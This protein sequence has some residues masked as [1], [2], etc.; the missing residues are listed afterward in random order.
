MSTLAIDSTV[1]AALIGA[2]ALVVGKLIAMVGAV[3][4]AAVGSVVTTFLNMRVAVTTAREVASVQ[5]EKHIQNRAWE[6]QR[7]GYSVVLAK[8]GEVSM[9]ADEVHVGH[10][11]PDAPPHGYDPGERCR[12]YR[13]KMRDAWTECKSEFGKN[14]LVLSEGFIHAFRKVEGSLLEIDLTEDPEWDK[15]GSVAKCFREEHSVLK[16]LALQELGLKSD[17][18]GAAT[19][20][21][22]T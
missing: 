15:A 18:E 20:P 9:Y 14:Q 17:E 7:A 2:G 4:G 11:G 5:Q 1:L 13:R 22:R 8:L 3:A 10:N 21:A 16:S 6:L 12:E 19:E